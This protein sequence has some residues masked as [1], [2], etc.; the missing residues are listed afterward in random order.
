MIGGSPA[1]GSANFIDNIKPTTFGSGNEGAN[2]EPVYHGLRYLSVF[3][4]IPNHCTVSY[5]VPV[6]LGGVAT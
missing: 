4:F 2:A 5:M 1:K 6:E 3:L